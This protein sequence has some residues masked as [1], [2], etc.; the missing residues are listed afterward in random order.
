[1]AVSAI[2]TAVIYLLLVAA[3]RIMGKRQ[4]G[5]LQPVELVVTLLVADMAA[6]AME[7]SAAPLAGG[8]IPLAVLVSLELLFS[9][10]LLK[11]PPL[12]RLI[13]GHPIPLIQEGQLDPA[14]MK[15][16]RLTI[17][18]LTGTLRQQGVFDL[19]TVR[20]AVAETGGKISVSLWPEAAPATAGDVGASPPDTGVPFVVISDGKVSRWG[21]SM[22]GQDEAWLR[23]TLEEAGLSVGQVFLLTADKSG[24]TYLV[25]K[26]GAA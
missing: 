11:C 5:D 12:A 2:R 19:A 10:L 1:M 17:E 14:A 20:Y 9:G 21:L 15:K 25:K 6:V 13:G 26:E 22:S 24:Q 23:R 16:L 8:L 3:M 18:D 4:L 7:D